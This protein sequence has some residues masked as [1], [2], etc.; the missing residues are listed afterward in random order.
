[1]NYNT[2]MKKSNKGVYMKMIYGDT[3]NTTVGTAYQCKQI[4]LKNNPELKIGDTLDESLCGDYF[5]PVYVVNSD[6]FLDVEY[7]FISGT[8]YSK[9]ETIEILKKLNKNK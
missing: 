8:I 7:R 4:I 6:D 2:G 9:E 5:T 1:M 3:K